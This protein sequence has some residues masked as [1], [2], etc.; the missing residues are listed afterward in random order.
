MIRQV[1]RELRQFER[2]ELDDSAAGILGWRRIQRTKT[3]A[4]PHGLPEVLGRRRS[5]AVLLYARGRWRDGPTGWVLVDAF[6]HDDQ[7]WRRS[8][9]W[10]DYRLPPA[11]LRPGETADGTWHGA[12]FYSHAPT[13]DEM[14]AFA[15]VSFLAPRPEVRESEWTV[16]TSGGLQQQAWRRLSGD[17]PACHQ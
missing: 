7:K 5:D 14:C 10:T 3:I 4:T 15:E 8:I 9:F 11:S 12:A 13:S 1:A 2:I 17:R 6:R 16:E